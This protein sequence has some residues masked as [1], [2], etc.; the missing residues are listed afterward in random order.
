MTAPGRQRPQ[1]RPQGR[2]ILDRAAQTRRRCKPHREPSGQEGQF[3]AIVGN[4]RQLQWERFQKSQRVRPLKPNHVPLLPSQTS[5]EFGSLAQRTHRVSIGRPP[6]ASVLGNESRYARC[7][8]GVGLGLV[9]ALTRLRRLTG[10]LAD[11]PWCIASITRGLDVLEAPTRG[12][13]FP[14]SGRT[15]V[16]GEQFL[17]NR[18]LISCPCSRSMQGVSECIWALRPDA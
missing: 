16:T 9:R 5:T 14:E 2:K 18:A 1:R 4:C 7:R 15:N 12:G 6:N 13:P 10:A 3:W 11:A 8:S 17:I